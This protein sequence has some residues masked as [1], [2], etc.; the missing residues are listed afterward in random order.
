M[1]DYSTVAYVKARLASTITTDDDR[2]G[3]LITDASR[4]VDQWCNRPPNGFVGQSQ[5]R[6]YDVISSLQAPVVNLR[7]PGLIQM[8]NAG[9]WP[10][11]VVGTLDIDPLLSFSAVNIDQDF[12]GLLAEVSVRA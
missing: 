11:A 3:R 5:V 6:V 12:D 7:D 1:A 4:A 8:Q 9:T 2:I 10:N